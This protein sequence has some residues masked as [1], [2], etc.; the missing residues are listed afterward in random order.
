MCPLGELLVGWEPIRDSWQT[1]A[2]QHLGGRVELR[3][4]STSPPPTL[5]FVVGF[6]RGTIEIDGTTGPVSTRATRG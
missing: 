2:N 1:Q 5:G 6:E 3:S 4:C